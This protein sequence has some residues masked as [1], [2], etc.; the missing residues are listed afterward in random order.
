MGLFDFFKQK[1]KMNILGVEFPICKGKKIWSNTRNTYKYNRKNF[2]YRMDVAL[3]QNYLMDIEMN[4]FHK[5]S[6][7]R[8]EKENAY[9]IVEELN[10]QLHIAFH[11]N[12]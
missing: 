11:V 7:V 8:Y 1:D 6:P 4:G 9:I 3:M 12:K 10:N 2:Y 5:A